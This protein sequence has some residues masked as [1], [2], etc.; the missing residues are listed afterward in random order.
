[1]KVVMLYRPESEFAR[2]AE[3]YV[4]E[5]KQRTS[6]DIEMIDI[7]SK[8]GRQMAELYGVIDHP[9]F[10]AIAN[11]GKFLQAWNGKPLP[12]MNELS[13]YMVEG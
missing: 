5:F 3:E 11:D 8:E 13:A 4:Y 2:G 12:L 9:A 10:L 1:M 6:K 7:D